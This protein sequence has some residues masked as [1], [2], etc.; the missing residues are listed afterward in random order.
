MLRTGSVTLLLVAAL[1]SACASRPEPVMIAA[2][3][4]PPPAPTPPPLPVGAHPGMVIPARLADGRYP[5]PS[6]A[7]SPAGA[8]WHLRAALNVAVL[9][10][11][12]TDDAAMAAQ[13]NQLLAAQR[14]PLAAAERDLAQEYRGTNTADA[15]WRPTYDAAMTRLYNFYA[16]DFARA[17]FCHAAEQVLAAAPTVAA[18]DL[19]AFAQTSLATLDQPFT[20]FYAAYD[21]WR[22]GGVVTPPVATI[23]TVAPVPIAPATPAAPHVAV[24]VAALD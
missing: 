12:G 2:A 24:D 13:Y 15:A 18:A 17:S 10:C 19:P 6:I 7:L 5:T 9:A 20:D 23:A 16:Q 21:A 1:T 8:T 11:R 14:A 3:P 22:T 4:P